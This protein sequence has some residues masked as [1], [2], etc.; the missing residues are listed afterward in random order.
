MELDKSKA[1]EEVKKCL[2]MINKEVAEKMSE[3]RRVRKER[4][5]VQKSYDQITGKNKPKKAK[6]KS[7]EKPK[8]LNG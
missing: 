6:E 7:E 2:D 1:I 3:L 8:N 5:K 4:T